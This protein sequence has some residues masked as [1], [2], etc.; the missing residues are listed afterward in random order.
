[1]FSIREI[2][3]HQLE[4]LKSL[5][6][7]FKE[8]GIRYFAIGGTALGAVRHSGFIPWDDDIDIAMLRE[9]YEK[10]LRLQPKLD[11][12]HFILNHDTDRNYP[13]YFSKVV[14]LNVPFFESDL[15]KY[16]FP[17]NIFIDIFPWD[18]VDDWKKRKEYLNKIRKKFKRAVPRN[19][20]NLLDHLKYYAYQLMNGFES[21]HSLYKRL[22]QVSQALADGDH[23]TWGHPMFND[24]LKHDQ[25]FPLR[26]LPFEDFRMPVPHKCEEYLAFKYGDY[27]TLPEEKDR[28]NHL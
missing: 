15:I 3:L 1:M 14:D 17:K 6:K 20:G 9:D 23:D 2:Q 19:R 26:Y 18:Q 16:D 8:S 10:F 22:D 25:I 4:M 13:L 12:N 11:K 27:M 24:V 5:D 21:S 7:V 28:V